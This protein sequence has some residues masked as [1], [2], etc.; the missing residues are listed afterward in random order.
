MTGLAWEGEYWRFRQRSRKLVK[1]VFEADE[2]TVP[3]IGR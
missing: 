1:L 3:Q 2:Q